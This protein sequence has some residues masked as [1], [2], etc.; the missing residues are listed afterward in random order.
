MVLMVLDHTRDFFFGFKPSP[1]DLQTTTEILFFTRWITHFCAPGFVFLAGMSAILYMNKNGLDKAKYFLRSRGL[2]LIFMEFV[3][4]R[5]AWKAYDFTYGFTMLQVLAAI[6][7]AMVF[8]SFIIRWQSKYLALLAFAILTLHG[9][10]RYADPET[11]GLF[12]F[13]FHLLLLP[14]LYEY[15]PGHN[16]YISY[17]LIPWL[18][19]MVLG[20]FAGKHYQNTHEF[21]NKLIKAGAIIFGLFIVFRFIN[22][23]GDPKPWDTQKN[24]SFTIRSF[25]NLGKYPPSLFFIMMTI[26]PF[27]MLLGKFQKIFLTRQPTQLH[28]VFI[29]FGQVPFFFYIAHAFLLQYSST[30]IHWIQTGT[31]D[32]VHWPLWA[33]YVVWILT[34][35]ILYYPCKWYL[36]KRQKHPILSYF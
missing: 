4:F 10:S 9:L 34:L 35:I 24:L 36:A 29:L 13:P 30:Y 15:L 19:V 33:T 12:S 17:P 16:F 20:L 1:T 14:K 27:L 31:I 11:F 22:V 5:L 32:H 3:V 18:S 26:G 21:A 7:F 25:F 23:Y 8:S 28:K 6:G 2:I